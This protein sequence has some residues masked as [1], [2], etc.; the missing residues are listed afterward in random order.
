MDLA[1]TKAPNLDNFLAEKNTIVWVRLFAEK[2]IY[3]K[4]ITVLPILLV[5]F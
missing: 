3:A 2:I 4:N 1:T 5:V